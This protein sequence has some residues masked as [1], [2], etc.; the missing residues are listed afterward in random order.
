MSNVQ[1]AS[2]NSL[3]RLGYESVV[4]IDEYILNGLQLHRLKDGQHRLQL[5]QVLHLHPHPPA[6][7]LHELLDRLVDLEAGAADEDAQLELVQVGEE[8]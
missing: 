5:L 7:P 2:P 3:G 1:N 8:T 4:V 6:H